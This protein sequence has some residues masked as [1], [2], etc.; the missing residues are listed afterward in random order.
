MMQQDFVIIFPQK[1]K[2]LYVMHC[3]MFHLFTEAIK[4]TD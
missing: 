2:F 1:Y 3:L 4:K